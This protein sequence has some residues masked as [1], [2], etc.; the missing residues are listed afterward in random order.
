MTDIT[1]PASIKTDYDKLCAVYSL[2]EQ[3]R[4]EH[5]RQGVVAREDYFKRKNKWY[6]YALRPKRLGGNVFHKALETLLQD[7]NRLRESIR[8]TYYT[9]NQWKSLSFPEK[10][11]AF[12]QLYGDKAQL[13]ETITKTTSQTLENLK[14]VSLDDL[15]GSPP[16]DPT[17]DFT[18]YTEVDTGG[19]LSQTADRSSWTGMHLASDAYLYD[20]KGV[21]H[22][23]GDFEHLVTAMTN[24]TGD[25]CQVGFWMLAN[26]LGNWY[27]LEDGAKNALGIFFSR[28][29]S[30]SIGF[31]IT[32]GELDDGD[33]YVDRWTGG[34]SGTVYY[35]TIKRDEDVGTYGTIYVYVYSDSDRTTLLD[36]LSL[37]LN[38]NK[39]DYRYIYGAMSNDW[40]GADN[41]QMT[42]YAEYL[43]LQ[44][45]GG[46]TEILSS[47]TG[48]GVE[49]AADGSPTAALAR[50]ETGQGTDTKADNPGGEITSGE[51]G[52]G[53]D[54]AAL[55]ERNILSNEAG[56][57]IESSSLST[58][59][60]VNRYGE[61]SGAGIEIAVK[62]VAW[63]VSDSGSGVEESVTIPIFFGEDTGLGLDLSILI[64]DA[65]D[66][67]AGNGDDSLKALIG[68][69]GV[70]S[71]MRLHG[72]Q[73]K[74][75]IPSKGVNI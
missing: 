32:L 50:T 41:G 64:K 12:Q 38:S 28:Y 22:F 5:N 74:T 51:A 2:I 54:T 58:G 18:S 55:V 72:R 19:F 11:A 37:G 49:V 13:K 39:K 25:N 29:V 16:P 56:N 14:G 42:G 30:Y 75:G 71:D 20:D 66:T 57:G 60:I 59:D 15:E 1:Y 40:M 48:I 33:G 63:I 67:D 65:F 44:E 34:T 36:T 45:T 6:L 17:E 10:E 26:D 21:N 47:D 31:G 43:D 8:K 3:M 7:Q 9:Q 53:I 23:N 52:G 68:T 70:N 73:G 4:L 46:E 69:V 61:E 62:T 35:V 27:T 24:M